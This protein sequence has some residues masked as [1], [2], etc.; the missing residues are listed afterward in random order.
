MKKSRNN[1]TLIL[2]LSGISLLVWGAVFDQL[3]DGSSPAAA[4]KGSSD[5][6]EELPVRSIAAIES[7][8]LDRLNGM[9]NPFQPYN[10]SKK[11][12]RNPEIPIQKK[13]ERMPS[14]IYRGYLGDA[15][16]PLAILETAKGQ[17]EICAV[18]D[19]LGEY[20]IIKIGA[21]QIHLLAKSTASVLQLTSTK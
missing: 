21:G 15:R 20:R 4:A 8:F 9:R 1:K 14:I 17:T 11:R 6:L 19:S 3:F 2:F 10:K 5:V 12:K 7:N 13:T 18:G 16:Q